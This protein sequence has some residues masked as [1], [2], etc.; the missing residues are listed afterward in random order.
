MPEKKGIGTKNIA[1]I[2]QQ[3]EKAKQVHFGY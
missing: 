3:L 1:R 2:L